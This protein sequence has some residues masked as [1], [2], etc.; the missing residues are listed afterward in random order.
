MLMKEEKKVAGNMT[1]E[2]GPA[3]KH[4]SKDLLILVWNRVIGKG[5]VSIY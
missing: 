5:K 4:T 2:G 1:C 3:E